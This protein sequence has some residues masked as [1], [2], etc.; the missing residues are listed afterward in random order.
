MDLYYKIKVL[1]D[2]DTLFYVDE[3][4][5]CEI[6]KNKY[7]F[8]S[9]PK[10]EYIVDFVCKIEPTIKKRVE[11]CLEYDRIL[12]IE[13]EKLLLNSP[14]IIANMTLLPEQGENGL[15]GYRDQKT[16]IL[17]IP[18][19]FESASRFE[20]WIKGDPNA[21]AE[22]IFDGKKRVINL[23]GKYII[24]YDYDCLTA[25]IEYWSNSGECNREYIHSFLVETKS[26]NYIINTNGDIL[27]SYAKDILIDKD[28]FFTNG[29]LIYRAHLWQFMGFDGKA[30][31]I[32]N[33][34]K[35]IFSWDCKALLMLVERDD[36]W[37]IC[38][39]DNRDVIPCNNADLH[40]IEYVD[41][42]VYL[43]F[44]TFVSK[45]RYAFEY[46]L[47]DECYLARLMKQ[48]HDLLNDKWETVE[49]SLFMKD[50]TRKVVVDCGHNLI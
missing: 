12:H 44:E 35:K 46:F 50:G 13:F 5:Y 45:V 4:F 23:K 49:E 6:E 1:S 22:V 2:V 25:D 33:Q 3:T 17:A 21:F 10:G 48:V 7:R 36:Y 29:V 38:T 47:H 32:A 41:S 31:V 9:L 18:Y 16:G 15:F 28:F 40:C 42:T 37:G 27:G 14:S 11:V 39:F 8:I 34:I 19:Q 26:R 20:Y 24:D 43:F 30:M